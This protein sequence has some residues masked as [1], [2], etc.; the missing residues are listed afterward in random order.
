PP[1]PPCDPRRSSKFHNQNSL[2]FNLSQKNNLSHQT[3]LLSSPRM[4]SGSSL[5]LG[6]L[7]FVNGDTTH[8]IGRKL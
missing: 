8:L 2:L 7:S 5:G 1:P 3:G 6:F 4:S